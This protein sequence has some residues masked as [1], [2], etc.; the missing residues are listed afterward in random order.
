MIALAFDTSTTVLSIALQHG[1]AYYEE[2]RIAG[3]NHSEKLLPL[4]DKLFDEAGLEPGMLDVVICTKGPG[5]FTGLR[6]GMS[7]A[8]GL[9]A[10]A[11]CDLV[12]VPTLDVLAVH[13]SVEYL[14]VVPVIDA[15]KDHFYTALYRNSGRNTDYL[16]I[17]GE[18][19]IELIL[20]NTP[21][22]I[23]GPAA[24]RFSDVADGRRIALGSRTVSGTGFSLLQCGIDLWET[25]IRDEK[26]EGPLYIRKS[27]AELLLGKRKNGR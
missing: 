3:L 9:A 25:G 1:K 12:S 21:A 18:Q 19:L 24:Y 4:I 13:P 6:I 22:L 27:D 11:S 17:S 26:S 10:G 7:T 14:T 2:T 23:T 8:K 20:K 5:S 15:K 16:D